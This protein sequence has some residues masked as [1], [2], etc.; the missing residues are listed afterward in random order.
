MEIVGVI[1]VHALVGVDVQLKQ[2][3]LMLVL[4]LDVIFVTVF[5]SIGCILG[6]LPVRENRE[7]FTT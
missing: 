1:V 3:V 5:V 4:F 6:V 7:G 2:K